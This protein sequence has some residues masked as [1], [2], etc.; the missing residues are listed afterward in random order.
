MGSCMGF[1]GEISRRRR[2]EG[3]RVK[4]KREGPK[5]SAVGRRKHSRPSSFEFR[6]KAEALRKQSRLCFTVNLARVYSEENDFGSAAPN[7]SESDH[8]FLG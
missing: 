6:P 7:L 2:K 1:V 8:F 5:E 3:S 4:E